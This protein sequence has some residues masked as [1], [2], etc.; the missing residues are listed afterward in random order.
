MFQIDRIIII[1]III[2]TSRV[3]RYFVRIY[4]RGGERGKVVGFVT[5][6]Q[7]ANLRVRFE[8]TQSFQPN[9]GPGVHS[10][11]KKNEFQKH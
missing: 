4:L 9:C 2:I 1:I 8:L 6:L 5:K 3:Y 10:A 7:A 11:S